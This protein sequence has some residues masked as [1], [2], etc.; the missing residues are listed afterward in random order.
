MLK[1]DPFQ[2]RNL[3]L[4]QGNDKHTTGTSF[5]SG[6]FMFPNSSAGAIV[7]VATAPLVLPSAPESERQ[8]TLRELMPYFLG[9]GKVE[10]RWASGTLEKY[11]D[12]MSWVIRWLGEIPPG[13]ITQQHILLIK[14]QCAKRNVGPS[15]IAHILAALKA[16]LRFCQLA[17]GIQTMDVRQIRLPRIPKR[18]VQFLTPD[19]IQQ[20]VAAIPLRNGPRSYDVDWLSFRVLVEV[21]LG[22]GA[23]ISEALSLK[24]SSINFQTGEATIIGKGNKE[25]VLFFSPRALN[26][27]KEYAMKRHDQGE[28]LFVVGRRGKPMRLCAALTR[29]RRFRKMIRFPKPVTAHML[30]HTVATTLLFNGC[31]IGHIKDILGHDRL[32]TT[33]NFYLGA[34]KR[35]AKKAHG[36]FLDYERGE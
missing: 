14:A 26:W 17:V 24:R 34:D 28:A 20:Y 25:R 22:T 11:E 32:I 36:D 1:I 19:E 35:A 6:R 10:L 21:L 16:F 13:R 8:A 9:Y 7:P 30:R 18:E 3:V 33:C 29:F 12:A 5:W 23:R 31:P 2:E 4:F 15:R 27:V